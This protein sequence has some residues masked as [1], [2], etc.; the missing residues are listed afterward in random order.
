MDMMIH[1]MHRCS[2]YH[3]C[4]HDTF[5]GLIVR[6]NLT[7]EAISDLLYLIVPSPTGVAIHCT[8][9]KSFLVFGCTI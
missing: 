8:N 7:N 1:C 3:W 2:N 6:H 9:L 5:V 4:G